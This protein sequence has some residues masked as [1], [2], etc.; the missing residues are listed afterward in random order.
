MAHLVAMDFCVRRYPEVTDVALSGGITYTDLNTFRMMMDEIGRSTGEPGETTIVFDLS[1][2][3]FIDS[4][5]LGMFLIALDETEKMGKALM[6]KSPHGNV[7]QSLN[8]AK[9][10]RVIPII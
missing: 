6:L 2:V 8:L 1:K 9:F 3:D 4:A 10:D 7:L 5:G